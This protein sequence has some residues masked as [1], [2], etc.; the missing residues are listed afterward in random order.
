MSCYH[1]QRLHTSMA[2]EQNI[3]KKGCNAN[4]DKVTRNGDKNHFYFDLQDAR[5]INF[6]HILYR[7]NVKIAT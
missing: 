7:S 3:L 5:D 1:R 6:K 4:I 2:I